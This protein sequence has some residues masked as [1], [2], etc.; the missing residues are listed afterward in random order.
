[1][2]SRCLSGVATYS[3]P[4]AVLRLMPHIS[5]LGLGT[6]VVPTRPFK[7]RV[8]PFCHTI[9]GAAAAHRE[10]IAT[11]FFTDPQPWKS[12]GI[13]ELTHEFVAFRSLPVTCPGALHVTVVTAYQSPSHPSH[14]LGAPEAKRR[15]LLGLARRRPSAPSWRSWRSSSRRHESGIWRCRQILTL[16][17]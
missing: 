2:I 3:W 16:T 5:P 7:F 4:V 15:L 12:L 14:S 13:A 17:L 8:R 6:G 10:P 9:R 11:L 1:L